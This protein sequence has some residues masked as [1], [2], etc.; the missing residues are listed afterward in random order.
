MY[1]IIR[2]FFDGTS[3]TIKSG[4]TKDE[5][6]EHCLDPETSSRTCSAETAAAN[7]GIWFDGRE[8]E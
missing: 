3:E 8:P 2:R 7:P 4:L 6:I 1:S 5:A